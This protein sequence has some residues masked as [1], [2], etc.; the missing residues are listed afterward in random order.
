MNTGSELGDADWFSILAEWI[1]KDQDVAVCL[2]R[3]RNGEIHER[4][5]SNGST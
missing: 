1:K 4:I 3:E 5:E 2:D